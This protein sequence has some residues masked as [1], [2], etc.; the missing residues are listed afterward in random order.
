MDIFGDIQLAELISMVVYT[1]VGV[2]LMGICWWVIERITPFS[3]SR[4]I[5]EDQNMALAVLIGSLFIALAIII[6]AV[7]TS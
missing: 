1:F 3:L 5:E 6:A 4:E 7:I 2:A